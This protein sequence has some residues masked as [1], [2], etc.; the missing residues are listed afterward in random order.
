MDKNNCAGRTWNESPAEQTD[1]FIEP[2]STKYMQSMPV[3]AD[4]KA[5]VAAARIGLGAKKPT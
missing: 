2:V 3:D 1:E 5:R 4:G